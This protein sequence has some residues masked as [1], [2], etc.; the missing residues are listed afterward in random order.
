MARF[1]D[2]KIEKAP[3]AEFGHTEIH[4]AEHALFNGIPRHT[5]VWMN[6][7]DR[8][9]E[10]PTGFRTIAYTANCPIAAFADDA[11][12]FYGFQFHP[13]V[14]HSVYGQ[15]MLQNFVK[16]ICACTGDWQMENLAQELVKNIKAQVGDGILV[17]GFSGGVDSSVATVLAHQ[18]L[19]SK[20]R[21]I[22]VDHG[23]LRKNEAKE[24]MDYYEGELGIP[25]QC[26]NA[27]ERFLQKINRDCGPRTKTKNN[28]S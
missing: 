24:I 21:C 22:L 3:W 8:V 11:R 27:Q 15:L 13:E 17:V 6:H 14:K 23:L 4:L 20:V 9:M 18:A 12:K 1:F 2:C 10:L 19:G 5:V 16:E 7:N 26:V 28:R 25:I